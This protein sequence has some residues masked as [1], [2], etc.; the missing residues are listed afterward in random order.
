ML[1]SHSGFREERDPPPPGPLNPAPSSH[2][3]IAASLSPRG[4]QCESGCVYM[5]PWL[6][7]EQIAGDR[8]HCVP[9][10][11]PP[12]LATRRPPL[13]A[14]PLLWAPTCWDPSAAQ[15]SLTHSGQPALTEFSYL[16]VT[17]SA[18]DK[19]HY[20]SLRCECVCARV[21]VLPSKHVCGLKR[22]AQRA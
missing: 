12:R 14:R 8:S 17:H 13:P 3:E 22:P 15:I 10:L 20:E 7:E 1:K 18:G 19:G 9:S 21:C 5:R 6:I 2:S 4:A 11:R 16:S